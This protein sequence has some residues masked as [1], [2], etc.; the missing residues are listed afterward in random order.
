[1]SFTSLSS[2]LRVRAAR[3]T[4]PTACHRSLHTSS[5]LR[6]SIL[7]ALGSLSNSRETQHF[8]KLT[9]LPRIEH[10]PPLKLI[11]TSEVDPFPLPT[12]PKPAPRSNA[13][14][15]GGSRTVLRVW[16]EKA[17][18]IGRV[19]LTEQARQTHRLRHALGRAKRRYARR[20]ALTKRD[21]LAWQQERLKLQKDMRAAGFWILASIGTA[22][23]LATWRF[24]PEMDRRN[25]T[26]DL[27]R[28]IAARAAA[29]M[30]LP[31]AVPPEPVFSATP[32]PTPSF[33]PVNEEN[34][35]PFQPP[36]TTEPEHVRSSGGW[37]KSLFWKQQ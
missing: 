32:P 22:T 24:W 23:A 21:K 12:P 3:N 13:W 15:I 9:R 28:K 1:M 6:A 18:Q 4:L 10:S 17:L 29:A 36:T 20:D 31:A 7:F 25:D 35:I 37:W 14:D 5:A 8:N 16:D 34:A 27:G 19:F 26:A 30:P 11:K 2:P 33:V